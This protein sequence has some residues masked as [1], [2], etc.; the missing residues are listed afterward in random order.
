MKVKFAVQVLN[1]KVQKDMEAF[2]PVATKSTQLFIHHCNLLWNVVNNNKPLST[3]TDSR[4]KDLDTVMQFFDNW[5]DDLYLL[6]KTKSEVSSHFISW[7]T[8]FYLKVYQ[9]LIQ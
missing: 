3:T 6:F 2:D 9:Y 5:R 1:D 8:M 4:I 7:Q